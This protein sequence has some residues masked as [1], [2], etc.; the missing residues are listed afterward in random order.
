[1]GDNAVRFA[2]VG[3]GGIGPTHAKAVNSVPDA[4]LVAVCDI[5]AERAQNLAREYSCD[6]YEDYA[7]MLERD[8]IDVVNVCTPSGLHAEQGIMAANAGKHVI[9]E[10]PIDIDLKKIDK[11]IL[12]CERRGVKLACIFQYRFTSSARKIKQALEE[13]RF[14]RLVFG[15]ADIKWYRKQAYYDS[16]D[17]RGTWA[18]DGGCLTNQGVHAVDL[19]SWFMGDIKS[20]EFSEIA[21]L[22]HK[23]EAEDAG[24]A[25]LRFENGAWGL[26]EGSTAVY[27]GLPLKIE[28]CGTKGSA[29]WG[30]EELLYWKIEG[31]EEEVEA[32]RAASTVGAAD[33]SISSLRGH[34]AQIADFVAAIKENRDPFVTGREARRA[35]HVLS[36]VYRKALGY[37]PLGRASKR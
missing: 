22:D 15:V 3:C 34:D 35:V 13:G 5:I 14:G 21:T 7:R 36:E 17:W 12:T 10:K 11:L 33:P 8:D 9:T 2:I 26:I 25:V 30:G 24:L 37:V 4:K 27:P 23:M 29:V 18:L 28:V 32:A 19:L 20:V 1:M 16:A 6:W 31:E